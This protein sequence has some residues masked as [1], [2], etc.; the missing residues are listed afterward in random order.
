L[1]QVDYN[2]QS[3]TFDWVAVSIQ[4]KDVIAVDVYPNPINYSS[5]LNM[6]FHNYSGQT[7]LLI[8]DF[9]GR[10]VYE[11][12]FFVENSSKQLFIELERGTYILQFINKQGQI[13]K[14]LIV[15]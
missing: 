9:S 3:E 8:F 12:E 15:K 10:K 5:S 11:S 7:H 1:T 13:L 2:G 14:K 6:D 4:E